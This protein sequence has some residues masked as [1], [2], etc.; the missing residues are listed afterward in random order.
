MIGG[1]RQGLEYCVP[2]REWRI[3]EPNAAETCRIDDDASRLGQFTHRRIEIE[4]VDRS[5]NEPAARRGEIAFPAAQGERD[6][7]QPDVDPLQEVAG[8]RLWHRSSS[9]PGIERGAGTILLQAAPQG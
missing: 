6:R 7:R 1:V 4:S 3:D 8:P 9:R 2:I 5:F